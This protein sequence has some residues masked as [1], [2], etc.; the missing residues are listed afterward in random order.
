MSKDLAVVLCTGS[1]NSAVATT[2]A[3]QK[4]RLILLSADTGGSTGSRKRGAYDMLV[5][6]FKPFREHTLPMQFLSYLKRS[7]PSA[8]LAG[9][10]P[11]VASD[12]SPRLIELTPLIAVAVR[13]AAHYGATAI[14]SG[15]RIGPD[16]QDLARATEYVQIWSEMIQ[17]PSGLAEVE[18]VTPLLELEPWQVVDLGVQVGTPFDKTWSCEQDTAEPCFV[19]PG[20]RMREAAFEQA[21]RV[22]PLRK[23]A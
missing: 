4:H 11:R 22:D 5:T 8:G 15:L 9:V 10:D 17:M 18:L 3:G 7:S 6:H 20:C 1:V 2:L 19:C 16:A 13:F 21:A 23:K 14:Y 12:L